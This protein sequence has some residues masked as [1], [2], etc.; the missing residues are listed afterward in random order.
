MKDN[1]KKITFLYNG[2]TIT[3][4]CKVEENIFER[5]SKEINK[6]IENISFLYNGDVI[7]E[8]FDLGSI[9]YYEI[10]IIIFDC[11]FEK[12]EKKSLKESKEIICPICK[13]LCEINFNNYKISLI[14]CKNKHCFPNLVINEFNDF[15]K[16]I[17]EKE[18]L[19]NKCQK[20][21]LEAYNNKF[22]I[23]C[24]CNINL[25]RLCLNSHDKKHIII[26]YENKNKLVAT[27]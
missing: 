2:E 13:E 10:K 8:D 1:E 15:Q 17:N 20:N 26:D 11:E 12:E 16:I 19:C 23:C 18:I 9:K 7:K 21:K 4:Q 14:N 6:D 22:F 5:F 24:N 25:C 3:I 27:M